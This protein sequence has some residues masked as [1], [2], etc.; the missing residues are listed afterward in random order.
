MNTAALQRALKEQGPKLPAAAFSGLQSIIL[1]LSDLY[2]YSEY[3]YPPSAVQKQKALEERIGF[4]LDSRGKLDETSLPT[5]TR[6]LVWLTVGA[7]YN[8]FDT[9]NDYS[10]LCL[11]RSLRLCPDLPEAALQY[12]ICS[13]KAGSW[14][15]A[16]LLLS[17]AAAL[18]PRDPEPLCQLSWL[19]RTRPAEL[20]PGSHDQAV[21][22][23]RRAVVLNQNNEHAW[24]NLGLSLLR[25]DV[26]MGGGDVSRA[27]QA[28]RRAIAIR[29]KNGL[30]YP[31]ARF[32]YAM[33]LRLLL[34]VQEAYDQFTKAFEEDPSFTQAA[35]GHREIL[36]LMASLAG[37][38]SSRGAV[39]DAFGAVEPVVTS[40][41]MLHQGVNRNVQVRLKLLSVV[42]PDASLPQ[43]STV[44]S[45]DGKRAVLCLHQRISDLSTGMDLEIQAP[46]ATYLYLKTRDAAYRVPAICVSEDVCRCM[47]VD[48]QPI[49]PDRVSG[50]HISVGL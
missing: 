48:G 2:S 7:A 11:Q 44:S 19:Y 35:D 5:E 43:F 6:A 45:E 33:L 31:D 18:A 37:R 20:Y 47:K 39:F 30:P 4:L 34:H 41:G 27:C 8:V 10:S 15:R 40:L 42:T 28:F 25:R 17:R 3:V 24:L 49:S 13:I 23:A 14:R 1:Q 16:E 50:T 46:V 29:E 38:I 9:Y 22:A 32:N 26:E 36:Q 12:G 21:S